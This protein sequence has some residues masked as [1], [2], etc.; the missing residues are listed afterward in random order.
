MSKTMP[1][2]WGRLVL[3]PALRGAK[4]FTWDEA[5]LMILD[6]GVVY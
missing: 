2:S 6:M 1:L 3:W 4:R 5:I